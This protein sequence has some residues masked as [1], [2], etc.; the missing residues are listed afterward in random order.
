MT[1]FRTYKGWKIE[2][3]VGDGSRLPQEYHRQIYADM[4]QKIIYGGDLL[5]SGW[6]EQGNP[7]P[8]IAIIERLHPYYGSP[9][10]L[11][12]DQLIKLA[13]S[14]GTCWDKGGHCYNEL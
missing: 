10:Y 11:T 8:C 7:D 1:N 6:W 3:G 9:D 5:S 2:I 14:G 4:K 12:R 13:V